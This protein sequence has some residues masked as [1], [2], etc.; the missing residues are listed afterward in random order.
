MIH[1]TTEFRKKELD[2]PLCEWRKS[3]IQQLW[4]NTFNL[5]IEMFSWLEE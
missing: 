1:N 2:V 5:K 4:N 3:S